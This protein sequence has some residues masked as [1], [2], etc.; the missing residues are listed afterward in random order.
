M[1]IISWNVNGIRAVERKEN[2]EE[3]LTQHDPDIFF[4][5][6]TKCKPEQIGKIIEK[7]SDYTQFY[8]SAEKPGY[9]GTAVWIKKEWC[10]SELPACRSGWD[11]ESQ[12][13]FSS[14]FEGNPVA[15]EGR[16][17]QIDFTKNGEAWSLLGLYFPNG[18]KSELAWAQ[19]LVFYDNFLAYVNR[20]KNQGKKVIFTGD[21]NC[22]HQPIDLAR[23]EDNDGVIG[24]HPEERKRLSHW[25]ENGW[26]DIWRH[27]KPDTQDVYSWWHMITRSRDRNVGWRIDYFFVDKT[28]MKDVKKIEYLTEQ[29][30]S[31]HCPVMLEVDS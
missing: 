3:F 5:Q 21:V 4:I 12:V 24:F 7:Y 14:Q 27:L 17:A 11:S 16:V 10:H 18:G 30:G 22:A 19:K 23:P 13:L 2:L 6:E 8:E 31:D 26:I 15:D 29:M 20:L 28:L 25:I 1:K 9:S